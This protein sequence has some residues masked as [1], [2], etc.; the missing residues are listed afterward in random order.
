[1]SVS[2]R[3]AGCSLTGSSAVGLRSLSSI[4]VYMLECFRFKDCKYSRA[5]SIP[6]S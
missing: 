3:A 1:M 2:V 6:K 4:A 5:A